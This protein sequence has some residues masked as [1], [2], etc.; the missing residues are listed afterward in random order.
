MKFG[1]YS[2]LWPLIILMQFFIFAPMLAI[3]QRKLGIF[4]V[5][6]AALCSLCFYF[7]LEET[8]IHPKILKYLWQFLIGHIAYE[9]TITENEGIINKIRS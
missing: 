3:I 1:I 2:Y 6:L 4:V 9:Y 5:I 7:F 8:A